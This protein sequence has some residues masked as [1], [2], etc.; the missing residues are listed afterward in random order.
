[1]SSERDH[2][3]AAGWSGNWSLLRDIEIVCAVVIE[4]KTTGAADRLGI[5]QSA[6]SRAIA[7]IETR[8]QKKLFH[9]EGGRLMPTAD[10]L[11]LYQ[12]GNSV[13][14]MLAGLE[15]EQPTASDEVV[16]LAPPT[17]SH[18]YLA[19]EIGR[20]AKVHPEIMVSLDVV[21]IE[22]LPGS[23]AEGRGD[24]GLT[25]TMFLHSGVTVEPFV[26]TPGICVLPESHPLAEKETIS[27][28]DLDGVNY[29]AIH[30]RHSLRGT[31]DRIFADAH[32]KPKITI[33][34]GGA[35]LAAELIQEGL[36]VSVLNPF[37]LVLHALDGI[38][39]RKFDADIQF[40][41]SFLMPGNSM[42]SVS[43]RIFLDFM[44]GRRDTLRAEL[45]RH[46]SLS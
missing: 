32:S 29:V 19:R 11:K 16:I 8:L 41:T 15:D 42:P 20:F 37:P 35:V 4:R 34:T 5:S 33:E 17:L 18:L 25:D 27:P 7:K 28:Q 12:Q 40:R 30:R 22:E 3:R 39:Y 2:R 14:E 43:T 6:V 45:A 36:G 31:L 38:A 13:F 10:A 23:I 9:R 46:P 21:T 1:M 44:K 24:V 26:E